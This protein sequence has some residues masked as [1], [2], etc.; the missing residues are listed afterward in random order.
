MQGS[1][2]FFTCGT[3][4]PPQQSTHSVLHAHSLQRVVSL[5]CLSREHDAVCS[6]QDG[7]SN[8]A[9]LGAG[10]ARLLDH[11]FQHLEENTPKEIKILQK[12]LA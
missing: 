10:R 5:G 9:A 4:S 11:A 12:E 8:V 2:L 6:V 7:I 1:R 3:G